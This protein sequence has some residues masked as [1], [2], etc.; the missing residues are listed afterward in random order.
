MI[1]WQLIEMSGIARELFLPKVWGIFWCH[2]P[3]GNFM[4]GLDLFDGR[5]RKKCVFPTQVRKSLLQQ[6]P[7]QQFQFSVENIDNFNDFKGTIENFQWLWRDHWKF[8]MVLEDA[9]TIEC[10]L[11]LWP[12][13]TM[14]F[15][16][17]LGRPTIGFNGFRWSR[18][19]GQTMGWFQW[20]EQ[21]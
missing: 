7:Y 12:L 16:W 11:V 18:T 5:S 19:I 17:F 20:I 6:E 15:Q 10:F 2:T 3:R 21:V 14:V 8:S 1:L 13:P 9:I 4:S